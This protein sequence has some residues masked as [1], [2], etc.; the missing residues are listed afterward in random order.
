M[1]LIHGRRQAGY[2][3]LAWWCGLICGLGVRLEGAGEAGTEFTVMAYNVENLF[4]VDGVALYED[5]LQDGETRAFSYG[6]AHLLTKLT[7]ITKLVQSVQ[8]GAGPDILMV[9]EM[10]FDRTPESGVKDYRAFLQEHAGTTVR[11]MLT[12]GWNEAVA[13]IPVEAMLLKALEDAGLGPYT[14][15][16]Q[17][18]RPIDDTVKAHTNGVFSR[19]PVVETRSHPAQDARDILEVVVEAPGGG[20]FYLFCNHWKS[21]ASSVELEAVRIQNAGV[22]RK[23]VNALLQADPHVDLLIA[24]DL[25]SNYNQEWYLKGKESG[26]NTVLGSQGDE[27]AIRKVNGPPVYNL[28]HELPREQRYSEIYRGRYGTLMNML[29]TRGLYDQRGVQYVD[30]SFARVILPGENVDAYGRPTRWSSFGPEGGG[31]SDHLPVVARFRGLSAEGPRTFITL[32]R[33]SRER[34]PPKENPLLP[35]PTPKAGAVPGAEV[36]QGLSALELLARMGEIFEVNATLTS[37]DPFQVSVGDQVYPLWIEDNGLFYQL[38][39]AKVG[40]RMGFF[41]E[42]SEHRGQVQLVIPTRRWVFQVK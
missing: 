18:A 5:Y 24:G 17:S 2:L 27:L 9:N 33:P 20:R 8:G 21:G 37:V 19:L 12:T 6:P 30:G 25:N 15:V 22:L 16:V 23:R 13:G 42:L 11:D 35:M 39:K 4:D 1:Y 29:I 26:I 3:F 10:E 32:T 36:L 34:I 14:V 38:K 28:W 31:Y 40:T 7:N 41:A